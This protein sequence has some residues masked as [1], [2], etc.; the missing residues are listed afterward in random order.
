VKKE[1]ILHAELIN[2]II[3][4]D[5]KAFE[6][7]FKLYH[8]PLCH[9]AK[10]YVKHPDIA[11]DI[12]QDTFIR[13][14]ESRSGLDAGQSLKAYLYRSVHNNCINYFRKKKVD[15][16]LTEEY[17]AEI[18]RRIELL[19]RNFNESSLERLVA[20]ELELS[21]QK[22]ID[23]LPEQ[24]REVFILSR[25]CDLS[26]QQIA[27]KLSVSINTVKTQMSRAMEKIRKNLKI[28]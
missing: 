15:N 14:W 23:G 11:D 27:D 18:L 6:L 1:E 5:Q 7:L 8:A 12:V 28:F 16:R 9:Y 10:V 24:C 4:G 13:I 25:Y 19:E 26:Y 20:Q 22:S 3:H 2:R 21:I 17:H